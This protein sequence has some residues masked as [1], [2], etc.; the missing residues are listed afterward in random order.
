MNPRY[1]EPEPG[2]PRFD[3]GEPIIP[4]PSGRAED[5]PEVEASTAPEPSAWPPRQEPYQAAPYQS[6]YAAT[7]QFAPQPEQR[8]NQAASW[9]KWSLLISV[10]TFLAVG[11]GGAYMGLDPE[12]GMSIAL[13]L[14]WMASSFTAVV[15]G[16][17]ALFTWMMRK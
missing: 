5:A 9:F 7:P 3:L 12:S 8:K 2:R 11:V 15:S 16:V 17:I 13:A 6:P 14:G 1:R 4:R 10:I